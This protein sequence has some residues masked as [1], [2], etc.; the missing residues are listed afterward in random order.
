[1]TDTIKVVAAEQVPAEPATPV[2][3]QQL[4][5]RLVA[6]AKEPCSSSY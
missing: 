6:Q 1:M 4:A 5:E 3:Q 2:D